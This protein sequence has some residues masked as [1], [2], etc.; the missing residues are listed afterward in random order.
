[1]YKGNGT[2]KAFPLPEGEDG[3]TVYLLAGG[4][5][6]RMA[7]GAAYEVKEG[8][9][10]FAAAPPVG[11]E[12]CFSGEE[13]AGAEV[14][15]GSGVVLVLRSDGTME[16]VSENPADL[17]V[18][19]RERMREA[20]A[21]L[22]EAARAREDARAVGEEQ[23]RIGEAAFSGRLAKYEGLAEESVKSAAMMARDD[24]KD[25]LKSNLLEMRNKHK[26]T[27]EAHAT[28]EELL[29][30]AKRELSELAEE[31]LSRVEEKRAQTLAALAEARSLAAE[32]RELKDVAG[33]AAGN[34]AHAAATEAA[35]LAYAHAGLVIE[36]SAVCGRRWRTRSR[37][38]SR[39]RGRP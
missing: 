29:K 21:M 1:M 17:L 3:R 14:P 5:K 8:S 22:K 13:G 19:A 4:K 23:R 36:E 24:I 37:R 32:T 39:A 38:P 7:E 26:A 20:R 33:D 11:A 10:V 30:S 25:A 2:T 28:V 9:A 27:V 16:E 6:V 34:A 18:E 15:A 12:V 31:A 35:N